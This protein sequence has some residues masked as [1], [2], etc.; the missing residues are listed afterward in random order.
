[1]MNLLSYI[2][3]KFPLQFFIFLSAGWIIID[4]GSVLSADDLRGYPTSIVFREIEG[5][6]S[7]AQRSIFLFTTDGTVMNWTASKNASWITIDLTA[8][9]TEGVLKVGVNTSSL[10]NGRFDRL[11]NNL[12]IYSTITLQITDDRRQL[13]VHHIPPFTCQSSCQQKRAGKFPT[14]LRL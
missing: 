8:G 6:A 10:M 11:D 13:V 7:A 4:Q 9:V 14:L 5:N 2:K 3:Y 12:T 1:M